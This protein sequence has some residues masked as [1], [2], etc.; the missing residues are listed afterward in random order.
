MGLNCLYM[1]NWLLSTFC[2]F[3]WQCLA[4]LKKIGC[5]SARSTLGIP[6]G[7]SGCCRSSRLSDVISFSQVLG[8]DKAVTDGHQLGVSPHH[9]TQENFWSSPIYGVR[10][11]DLVGEYCSFLLSRHSDSCHFFFDL[12]VWFPIF[13]L[14]IPLKTITLTIACI[15]IWKCVKDLVGKQ[16][17]TSAFAFNLFS[18]CV[19]VWEELRRSL[20]QNVILDLRSHI[21]IYIPHQYR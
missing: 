7:A 16:A 13:F 18:L 20:V 17:P 3:V 19:E 4:N 5:N 21:V 1:I 12:W 2:L 6:S 8:E 9:Q 10:L 11:K 14:H 15:H